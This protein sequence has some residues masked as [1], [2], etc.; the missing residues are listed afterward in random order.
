[1]LP[2]V[3]P[4]DE[5]EGSF[6]GLQAHF[7]GYNKHLIP[8]DLGLS[9]CK[10]ETFAREKDKIERLAALRQSLVFGSADSLL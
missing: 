10:V 5:V 6:F 9:F 2:E 3:V 8:S 4:V 1:M 7:I